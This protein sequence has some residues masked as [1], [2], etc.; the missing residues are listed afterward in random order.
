MLLRAAEDLAGVAELA[1]DRDVE[2]GL[3]ILEPSEDVVLDL[4][5]CLEPAARTHRT[6]HSWA[7]GRWL[8][9]VAQGLDTVGDP[10]SVAENMLG[11]M[12]ERN[13]RSRAAFANARLIL[14]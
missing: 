4:G 5:D 2:R 12:V 7:I 13:R 1:L 10:A 14:S 11:D 3:T 9:P 6:D 8:P